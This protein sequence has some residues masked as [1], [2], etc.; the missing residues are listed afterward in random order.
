MSNW[1]A[2]INE[3][4]EALLKEWLKQQRKTQADLSKSLQAMSTRMP[5]LLEVLEREYRLGGLTKVA[6]RLCQIEEEWETSEKEFS[7]K[8]NES[9]SDPFG[10]L[11]LILQEIQDDYDK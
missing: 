10:Q 8:E 7:I 4:F 2:E 6:E 1:T 11:D 9:D 3:E 5:A